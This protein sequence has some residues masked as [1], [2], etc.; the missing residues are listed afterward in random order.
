MRLVSA[1]LPFK[2]GRL[3]AGIEPNDG[4]RV[5]SISVRAS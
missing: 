2:M 5:R 1:K 4:A 3:Y